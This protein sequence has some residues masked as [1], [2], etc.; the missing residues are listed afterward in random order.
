MSMLRGYAIYSFECLDL[1]VAFKIVNAITTNYYGWK[2][3]RFAVKVDR[4]E[5]FGGASVV[6]R[7]ITF[8]AR[9]GGQKTITT[10]PN[11]A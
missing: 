10:A 4:C 11:G 2:C 8:V 9:K 1:L 7:L 5:I 3:Q 6:K